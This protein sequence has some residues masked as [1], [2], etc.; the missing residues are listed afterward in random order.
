MKYL[1][2]LI[3]I[4]SFISCQSTAKY[5]S[6]KNSRKINYQKKVS[7]S[8]DLNYYLDEWLGVPY[9]YGGMSKRG[10]DCSG[11]TTIIFKDVYSIELPRTA[12]DQYIKGRKIGLNQIREGDLVFFRGVRGSGIDHVGIYL[13]EGE[14]VHASISGGVIISNLNDDYYNDR[15]VGVC[16]Y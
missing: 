12:R 16:R 10:V 2:F 13:S 7:Y 1:L 4:F 15:F 5:R 14:F 8:K 6:I 9:K 3:L 11:L